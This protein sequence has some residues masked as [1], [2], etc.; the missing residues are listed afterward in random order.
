MATARTLLRRPLLC[1]AAAALFATLALVAPGRAEASP[2]PP[3]APS[4][5][6][7]YKN[8]SS[9]LCLSPAGGSTVTNTTIVQYRCDLDPS[10]LWVEEPDGFGTVNIVNVHSGLCL[11]PAGRDSGVNVTIVQ[12]A[13]TGGDLAQSWSLTGLDNGGLGYRNQNDMLC[14]SPAGGSTAVNASI[15][16]YYCDDDP[17]RMWLP[18]FADLVRD[19]HSSMCLSPASD[20]RVLNLGV[21]QNPCTYVNLDLA[22]RVVPD[23][24]GTS[25]IRN[26]WSNLCLSP[27][28]GSTGLNM[29]I[30]EYTCDAD[31]SRGWQMIAVSP[32]GY[33]LR[34]VHS[35][36]CMSPAGGATTAGTTVVQYFCDTDPARL[37]TVDTAFIGYGP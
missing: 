7:K 17:A 35:G 8:Q 33:E 25:Y 3:N 32:T 22:W 4:G 9:G 13:C 34:N 14:L 11:A 19:Q 23:I 37:W 5:T 29:A 18:S 10:R 16:Q 26:I 36:L 27:A 1:G 15:V 12:V 30:V 20:D 31:P 6:M 24:Y 28:G 21:T 2:P